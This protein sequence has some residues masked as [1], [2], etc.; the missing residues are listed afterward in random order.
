VSA[1]FGWSLLVYKDQGKEVQLD[2]NKGCLGEFETTFDGKIEEMADIIEYAFD[3]QIPG[4]LTIQSDAQAAI[5]RL[6]HIGTG[7]G[8]DRAPRGVQAVQHR[9]GKVG[10]RVSNGFQ[11]I[12]ELL[13]L[14][15]PIRSVVT[16]LQRDN[17]GER[18]LY[19]SKNGSHSILESQKILKL[20]K[21]KKL[22]LLQHRRHSSWIELRIGS[23]GLLHTF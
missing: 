11:A 17:M 16:Q 19:G 3:N 8:Q 14:R 2:Y 13:E 10:V 21:A 5:C 18:L 22:F 12:L 6:G 15:G 7:P 4:E 9:H 20:I 23:P 1:V